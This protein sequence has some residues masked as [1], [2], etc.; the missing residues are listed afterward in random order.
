LGPV[1]ETNASDN[2]EVIATLEGRK[3]FSDLLKEQLARAK[4]KMKLDAN[5]KRSPR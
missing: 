3:H 4:N 5:T 2:S 1:P